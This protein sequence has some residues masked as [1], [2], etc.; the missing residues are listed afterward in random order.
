MANDDA[1]RRQANINQMGEVILKAWTDEDFK[2]RLIAD[3]ATVLQQSGVEV[4][5]GVSV[6][7]LEDTDEVNY[8]VV[9]TPPADLEISDFQSA[10]STWCWS[11]NALCSF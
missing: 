11:A 4:P 10:D 1:A 3:P 5:P 9:P 6:K 2:Q 8:F 7:V